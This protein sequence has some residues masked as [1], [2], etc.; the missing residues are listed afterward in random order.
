MPVQ[1]G[2]FVLDE[3]RR[4]LLRGVDAVHLSPKAFQMLSILVEERPRAVSKSALQDRLW[5]DTFVTEGNLTT[6]I[7]EL[8]SALGDD[9]R[10]PRFIRTVHRFGYSFAASV[11][12]PSRF[13]MRWKAAA[14][15][16]M[17]M[18]A[19]IV[20]VVWLRDTRLRGVPPAPIQSLAILPFDTRD[21]DPADRHL[22]VGLSDVM[23]T[24]LSNVHHLI[25]RPT[26]AVREFAERPGDSREIGRRLKVDAVLE[27]SIRT[28]PDR[29]RVTV[30]LLSIREQRTIWADQFDAQRAQIFAIEDSISARV[31][32]A[33]MVRISP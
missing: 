8:R 2:E 25:V 26:S 19:A 33:L 17:V 28:S 29:I 10:E 31:A 3:S 16:G 12:R 22:G 18:A 9:A 30:Q 14:A 6:T 5:P 27:G 7:A 21:A 13:A 15:V 24:R 1:F 23:I 20:L 4:Q 32:D 11:N